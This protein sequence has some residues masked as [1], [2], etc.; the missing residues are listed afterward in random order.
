M[1]YQVVEQKEMVIVEQVM[2]LR[3]TNYLMEEV[4]VVLSFS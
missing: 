3:N 1:V 2:G 4:E